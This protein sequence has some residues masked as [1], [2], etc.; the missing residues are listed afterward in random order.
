MRVA[1]IEHGDVDEHDTEHGSASREPGSTLDAGC[2]LSRRVND[3]MQQGSAHQSHQCACGECVDPGLEPGT[4]E[5]TDHGQ[6]SAQNHGAERDSASPARSKQPPGSQPFRQ[7]MDDDGPGQSRFFTGGG[8]DRKHHAIDHRMEQDR[9]YPEQEREIMSLSFCSSLGFFDDGGDHQAC[10][11][12]PD[13]SESDRFHGV[14]DHLEQH[15]A[16]DGDEYE[17]IQDRQQKRFSCPDYCHQRS[18]QK[19]QDAL[20]QCRQRGRLSSF[21]R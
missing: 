2:A 3:D 11:G 16:R 5:P 13:G 6:Q 19:N 21:R 20:D 17:A 8:A 15:H 7:A 4:S 9:Q 1:R 14:G 10:E 18:A 12:Q